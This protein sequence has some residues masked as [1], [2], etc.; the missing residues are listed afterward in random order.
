VTEI[1]IILALLTL[2][3]VFGT[4]AERRH[5]KSILEREEALRQVMVFS[6]RLP[7]D[8][9]RRRESRLVSGSVCIS[10]D[11]FKAFVAGLRSLV[12]GR[13]TSYEGLLDRGR[14][15]AVLRMKEE[16]RRLGPCKIFNVKIETASISK[17][18]GGAIGTLEVLAYGT[19]V[20]DSP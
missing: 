9:E 10:V 14:R 8:L 12:G 7:P 20:A 15:E 16:A 2:G 3:Y 17:G 11:Y 13:V 4:W 6:A 5:Y 1:L 18:G 19:A